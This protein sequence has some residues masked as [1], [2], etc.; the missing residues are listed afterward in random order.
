MSTIPLDKASQMIDLAI[1]AGKERNLKPIAAA[2]V[3]M[4]GNLVAYKRA[5]GASFL[6]FELAYGKAYAAAALGFTRSGPLVEFF[7]QKPE[8]GEFIKQ[9]SGGAL[10]AD[11]G[12]VRIFDDSGEAVGAIGV[13]GDV[14]VADEECAVAA[15][16]GAGF[17]VG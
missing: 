7:Q 17:Q 5:D 6:R 13:T 15:I 4:G 2:V 11:P 10:L 14:S 16:E 3:D 8:L 12:G 1:S 9:A